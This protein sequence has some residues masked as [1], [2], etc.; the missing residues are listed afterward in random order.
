[1]K[2]ALSL[3]MAVVL[4]LYLFAFN[5]YAKRGGYEYSSPYKQSVYYQRLMEVKLTS[6]MRQN[7][8]NVA[9]SQL[10]YHEGNNFSQLNGSNSSGDGN[11]TEYGYWIGT[12]IL[13][14]GE[15]YF[16]AW[17]AMFVSWCARQAGIPES[18]IANAV[19]A[20]LDSSAEVGGWFNFHVDRK[21]YPNY[22]P[23]PGDLVFFSW[24]GTKSSWDHVGIVWY[25]TSTSVVTIEGNQNN[26]VVTCTYPLDSPFIIC[27]GTPDYVKYEGEPV[28][29]EL[30]RVTANSG[31]N[32]RS[33]AGT[34]YQLLGGFPYLTEIQVFEKVNVSGSVWGKVKYNGTEGWCSLAYC[35]YI[36][37]KFT[38][39]SLA[40]AL[41]IDA[42]YELA[43]NLIV[44]PAPCSDTDVFKE[45]A[46]VVVNRNGNPM[47][48]SL[49]TGDVVCVY[50]GEVKV[51]ENTVAV[52]GDLSPDGVYNNDDIIK[53]SN[54]IL[55]ISR[56]KGEFLTAA[57]MN[58]N[59]LVGITDYIILKIK[60]NEN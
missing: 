8:V 47:S 40:D 45:N 15:G 56:L 52:M 23:L 57:D 50:D 35:K 25:T 41:L 21:D 27:F 10:G 3:A 2:K 6:D 58:K 20:K 24:D 1:M 53:L 11:Y 49:A 51:F 17:C 14:W 37:G 22:T 4:T 42:E 29:Y 18:I 60:V 12:D 5:T 13:N 26:A 34:E 31:L 28:G 38:P 54:H 59:G 9:K 48:G 19:R 16:D 30:W 43:D 55:Q 46:G 36:E 32:I 39:S 44:F 33:G 7:I